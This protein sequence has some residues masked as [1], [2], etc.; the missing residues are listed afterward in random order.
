[1][2]CRGV[3]VMNATNEIVTLSNLFSHGL[4]LQVPLWSLV[5]SAGKVTLH[6]KSNKTLSVQHLSVKQPACVG[7]SL[8]AVLCLV[9]NLMA[10]VSLFE[11]VICRQC[12]FH[13]QCV[14]QCFFGQVS[15]PLSLL[16][17]SGLEVPAWIY[18]LCCILDS[19]CFK[20]AC[21]NINTV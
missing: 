8:L 12:V 5:A 7:W 9:K 16:P 19:I 17:L 18:F 14:I 2:D 11:W 10:V 3:S 4:P 6:K 1:M 13:S 15:K 20:Q 21:M